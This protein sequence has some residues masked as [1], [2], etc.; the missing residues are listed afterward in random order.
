M[1]I[2]SSFNPSSVALKS[3]SDSTLDKPNF[4]TK[5]NRKYKKMRNDN[6]PGSFSN[7]LVRDKLKVKK[8]EYV[9]AKQQID[10]YNPVELEAADVLYQL[11]N[12][13]P[14]SVDDSSFKMVE[15]KNNKNSAVNKMDSKLNSHENLGTNA[16]LIKVS[17]DF[18]AKFSAKNLQEVINYQE[19]VRK[20]FDKE[21]ASSKQ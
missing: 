14:L 11:Q 10:R 20:F 8:H 3:H 1:T 9:K 2:L 13:M 4:V 15:S 21:S 16:A 18:I 6:G 17:A 19:R 5:N 12:Y 7:S